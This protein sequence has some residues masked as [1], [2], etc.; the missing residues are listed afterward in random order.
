VRIENDGT[1]HAGGLGGSDTARCIFD[2]EAC[3]RSQGES[4]GAEQIT[5]GIG[6]AARNIVCGNNLLKRLLEIKRLTQS[7]CVSTPPLTGMDHT[8]CQS[9]IRVSLR[10]H[11]SVDVH[12]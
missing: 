6:F 8:R 2:D 11:Q 7:S 4:L 9:H 3:I 10:F 12:L 5:L 1:A